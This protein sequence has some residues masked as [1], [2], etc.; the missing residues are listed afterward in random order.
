[1]LCGYILFTVYY[2]VL[3]FNCKETFV[4]TLC[5][6]VTLKLYHENGIGLIGALL[7]SNYNE[8]SLISCLLVGLGELELLTRRKK[9]CRDRLGL[10]SRK[11]YTLRHTL[12][13]IEN[14][15][16][17]TLGLCVISDVTPFELVGEGIDRGSTENTL[18]IL[19]EPLANGIQDPYRFIGNNT[20]LIRTYV[21]NKV[22]ALSRD[23]RKSS[24][25]LAGICPVVICLA[26]TPVEIERHGSFPRSEVRIVR[27]AVVCH[28]SIVAKTVTDTSVDKTVRLALLYYLAELTAELDRQILP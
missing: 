18:A 1:M 11:L 9:L 15:C 20:V 12:G 22:S 3:L 2:T 4:K 25:N 10:K 19:V 28:I 5:L 26:I 13:V 14:V 21:K 17:K 8:T 24:D 16:V 27:N 6:K 23:S 7:G